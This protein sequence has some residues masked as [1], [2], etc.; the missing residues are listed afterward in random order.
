M[1][2]E[3]LS[4]TYLDRKVAGLDCSPS[5]SSPNTTYTLPYSVATD[6]TEGTVVVVG[7]DGTAYTVTRPSATSVSVSGVDTHLL[8]VTIGL[9]YTF[10]V[11]LSPIIYRPA[12]RFGDATATLSGRLQLRWMDFWYGASR[13]AK[14][15]V[16]PQ[17]RTAYEY[18]LA[19]DT[20]ESDKFHV[21]L[22]TK[23][24]VTI[25]IT[26]DKPLPFFLTGATWEGLF[27]SRSMRG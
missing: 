6:G 16:T 12:L 25:T 22:L 1:A 23:N 13:Y 19:K 14:V 11:T 10:T 21:P 3:T 26:N 24:D 17:G 18:V 8:A 2:L 15:T 27:H 9:Q 20:A 5:Y 7:A 4:H